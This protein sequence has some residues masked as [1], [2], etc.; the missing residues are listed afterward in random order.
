[1]DT[2]TLLYLTI[3]I[4]LVVQILTGFIDVYALTFNYRGDLLLI[5]GLI[6][7]ELIVQFIEIIFYSWFYNGFNEIKNATP[8][9]YYDWVITTP[10]MLFILIVYLD[11]LRNNSKVPE[12]NGDENSTYDYIMFS[13]EKNKHNF[14]IIL[15]L[16]F[17]MLVFGYL[18][19]I[20][21]I[22][23][24]SAFMF[25]FLFFALYF[26]Y[27]YEKYAKYTNFGILMITLFASIWA[28]YGFA[29]LLSYNWKN[30]SYNLL[31]IVSKNF[32]GLFLAYIGIKNADSF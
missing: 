10:S 32:F 8:K 5:K 31:D 3:K 25:G 9:R 17:F 6:V 14:W 16:N 28:L 19:E 11:Y 29:S 12:L 4:S 26:Y 15:I 20:N 24:L 1:M 21:I 27:I 22:S 13:Y 30:I 7:I 2:R 23:K 18:G